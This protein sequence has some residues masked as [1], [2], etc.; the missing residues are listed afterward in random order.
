MK[1]GSPEKIVRMIQEAQTI[2]IC[3][4]INPDGDTLGCAT[5]MRIALNH[6]GKDV[7]M[8]CDSKIPDQLSFLP[9]ISEMR[10]PGDD[11]GTYDL[12]ITV[13][14]SDPK[15]LGKCINLIHQSAH[16]AQ[17]DHHPT[18][19]VFM[20]EN[21][22]DGEAP[23]TCL[24]IRKMLD[25]LGTDLNPEIAVS[26][27][28]GVSTDTGN[29]AFASSNAACFDLM[30]E[31]MKQ[32]LPLAQLN[33]I[34]FRERAMPQVLLIGKALSSLKYHAEGKIAVM[35]LT[36]QDFY[37]CNA[38]SEHAD[39]LVNFGLDTIGTKM[40]LLAREGS[41]DGSVKISLRAKEPD[42]VS[43]IAQSFG[44]GGHPQAAG[45][46]M[47]GTLDDVI[48]RVLDAMIRKLNG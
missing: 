45:I 19:P 36:R 39:T 41:E 47:Y 17:I 15:R 32:N 4:H 48:G 11:E 3:S 10:Y 18:N 9:G 8:F 27:Y 35:R 2:A 6:L 25:Y 7:T 14:V 22:V 38:L 29:F 46:T 33:R 5:A 21:W 23:A 26:L 13:D 12:L 31:L 28:T 34:L 37:D 30:S 16:T 42:S 1:I 44:G 24:L 40:A 43:D 20:E